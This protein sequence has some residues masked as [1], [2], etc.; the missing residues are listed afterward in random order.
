MELVPSGASNGQVLV[1]NTLSG[2]TIVASTFSG[3]TIVG[4]TLSGC[5]FLGGTLS[6]TTLVG[7]TVSGYT[8]PATA[9]GTQTGSSTTT[10]ITPAVARYHQSACKGWVSFNGSGVIAIN[11][12]YNVT[13]ITDVGVGDYT[14][15]WDEDF[16]NANYCVQAA[17]NSYTSIY[18]PAAG[19]AEVRT[20]DSAGSVTDSTTVC[21][22]SFGDA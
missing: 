4:A 18:A 2:A 12:S 6:G 1:G 16:A 7:C 15:V 10:G 22:A 13:S 19:S 3:G 20:A 8:T 14:V 5:T 17:S 21:V 9:T 11:D